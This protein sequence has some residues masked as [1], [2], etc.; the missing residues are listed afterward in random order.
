[1][2]PFSRR[3]PFSVAILGSGVDSVGQ[4]AF[5]AAVFALADICKAKILN[6]T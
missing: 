6:I 2:S 5:S 1:M 3:N 4:D